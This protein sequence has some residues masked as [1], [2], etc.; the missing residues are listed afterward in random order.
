[1]L[2][3][4]ATAIDLYTGRL[5]F[6]FGALPALGAVVALDRGSVAAGR[7]AGLPLSAVQPGGRAVRGADRRRLRA[8]RAVAH[9]PGAGGAAGALVAAAALAP[10][11]VLAIA[12]PEGGHEPFGFPT[13]FPVLV[14]AAL[15]LLCAP[16]DALTLRAGVVIYALATIV[17]YLVPSPIGSNIARLGTFLAAP[18]GALLLAG[19]TGGCWRVALAPAAVPRV[20][21]AGARP[22]LGLQRPVGVHR[23]L[24]AAAALSCA[25]WSGPAPRRFARRSRSRGFTGRR[26]WSP[27]TSR[28]PAAGSA[29]STSPTTR[30]STGGH[31]TAATYGRWLH[32]NAI[33]FVAA[34][35]AP[36]DYSAQ[37]EMALIDRGL[38]Y[39]RLVM[40]SAHWR[41]YQVAHATP[42]AAGV[43]TLTRLG[44]DWLALRARRPGTV[45][46]DVRFTPY[47]MLE[48][49]MAAWPRTAPGRG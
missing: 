4:A 46:L 13:M 21:G 37:S 28:W 43:A 47:W 23:L 45:R 39:L 20:G 12:F 36:L 44:P 16:R 35:D 29:S 17:V 41:V 18:L 30:S 33:R 27:R 8:R 2:F 14:L 40:R 3:G 7:R 9:A 42:I 48:R 1:M 15:A 6:A 24:P 25:T 49:G 26:G 11:G 34:P 38:P 32:A 19:A 31:L 10:V 22:R 5:A